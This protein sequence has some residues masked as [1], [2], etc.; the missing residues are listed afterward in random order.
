[1]SKAEEFLIIAEESNV[2]ENFIKAGNL[3]I[4]EDKYNL[5]ALAFHRAGDL[6]TINKDK[7]KAANMYV[8]SV[9]NY[10]KD[11]QFKI[12]QDL[13]NIAINIYLED[14]K[15]NSAATQFKNLAGLY[16]KDKQITLAI[17]SYIKAHKYFCVENS[18]STGCACLY[19]A[20]QLAIEHEKYDDAIKLLIQ[21]NEYYESNKLTEFKSKQIMLEIAILK[22]FS[23]DVKECKSY[24][25]TQ[26]QHKDTREYKL[27]DVLIDS[28][29]NFCCM[30]FDNAVSEFNSIQPLEEW[31][32]KLLSI[33]KERINK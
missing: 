33:V 30:G 27:L 3:C 19:K 32:T 6:Y 26:S 18:Q 24:L 7:Y 12:A 10:V 9:D 11:G 31:E 13:L 22:L 15:F 23:V 16:Q 4:I 20:S 8:K 5:A 25:S 2:I 21:I 1:M 29:E 28:I 14:G 17:E